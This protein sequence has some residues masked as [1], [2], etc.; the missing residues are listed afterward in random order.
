MG[1]AGEAL[2]AFWAQY[3]GIRIQ[4]AL[5]YRLLLMIAAI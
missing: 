2:S 5:I 1:K 4:I 3:L